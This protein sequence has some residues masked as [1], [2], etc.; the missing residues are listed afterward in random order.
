MSAGTYM[1]ERGLPDKTVP[2]CN[3]ALMIGEQM[4]SL[5]SIEAHEVIRE[6][7][8]F[9][10]IALVE[11]NSHDKSQKHKQQ[12]LDMLLERRSESGLQIRDYELG[13]AYN[14]IG[15]AYGNNG[16]CKQAC[17]AFHE[18]VQIFQGLED[19]TDTMLGWPQPNLGFMYW[20]LK[21]YHNAEKVLIEILDI[22]AIVWGVDDTRSFKFFMGWATY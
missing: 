9:I 6:G 11:T 22:H 16:L 10:G 12:W 2:F 13:Y 7:H 19:Y 18:S 15:V 8:S 4:K 3:V 1:F 14:E 17:E 21:D 5:D 20:L